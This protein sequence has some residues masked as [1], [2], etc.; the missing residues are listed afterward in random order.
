[1]DVGDAKY[2]YACCHEEDGRGDGD[3]D[4]R[5]D[6]NGDDDDDDDDE[7][8]DEHHQDLTSFSI[9]C[10]PDAGHK[11]HAYARFIR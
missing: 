2:G 7:D 3:G 4:N 6:G 8:D 5:G 9:F 10:Y 11:P 1:M